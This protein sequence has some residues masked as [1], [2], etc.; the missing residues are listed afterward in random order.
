MIFYVCI[1]IL[2]R[3]LVLLLFDSVTVFHVGEHSA[4]LRKKVGY[5]LWLPRSTTKNFLLCQGVQGS[6]NVLIVSLDL[7]RLQPNFLSRQIPR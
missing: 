3:Y 2:G 5:A 7:S 4:R 6:N 1:S